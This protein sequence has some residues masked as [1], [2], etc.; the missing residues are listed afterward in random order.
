MLLR[1]SSRLGRGM[2]NMHQLAAQECWPFAQPFTPCKQPGSSIHL[3][4]LLAASLALSSW[5]GRTTSHATERFH[6]IEGG[7]M[8]TAEPVA[9]G[10]WS[11]NRPSTPCI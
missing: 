11:L 5:G 4:A 8:N 3:N 9:W 1:G 7:M 6:C 2:M 10:C